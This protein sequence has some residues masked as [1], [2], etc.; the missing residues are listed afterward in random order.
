LVGAALVSRNIAAHLEGALAAKPGAYHPLIY[1]WRGG[2][3]SASMATVLEQIGWRVGL[4][5]GGYRTYRRRVTAA[6][7]D[8]RAP[9]KFLLVSGGTGSGKTALLSRAAAHGAQVLDLE[10]LARHRGSLFGADPHRRQPSQKMFESRLLRRLEAMDIAK[11]IL[12]EAEASRIGDLFLP[13]AVTKA[14]ER[15]PSVELCV[16]AP[17]RAAYVAASYRDMGLDQA[18]IKAALDALPRHHSLE[19]KSRWRALAEAGE[20]ERLALD[21]IVAHYDPAYER[22]AAK[23]KRRT[24]KEIPLETLSAAALDK[25]AEE[26]AALARSGGAIGPGTGTETD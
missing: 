26:A 1:C 4:L 23:L 6:L 20:F 15:A 17:V 24:L 8:E 25:A 19:D 14:M 22:C 9:F 12:V 3:R 11:T 18:H 10:D 13:P 7:Y 5:K 21:L 2:Q 16:P